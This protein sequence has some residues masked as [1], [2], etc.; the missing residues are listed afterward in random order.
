MWEEV[1]VAHFELLS[2]YVSGVTIETTK[3]FNNDSRSVRQDLNLGPP[4]YSTKYRAGYL[5][6][7]CRTC[8]F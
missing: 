6:R 3:Y 4:E 8:S 7:K 1:A 2:W 5:D